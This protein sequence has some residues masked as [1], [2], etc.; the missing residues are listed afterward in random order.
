MAKGTDEN[1][2][3][4]SSGN[5]FADLG[6]LNA[7][8]EHTKV[9][10]ALAINKLIE[11]L[12]QVEAARQLRTKQPNVS[13]LRNYRLDGFSAER[14]MHF[15]NALGQDV[16]IVIRKR[17][18]W[19]AAAIVVSGAGLALKRKPRSRKHSPAAQQKSA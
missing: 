18:R 10:L 15:L 11:H 13:A 2:V 17:P 9:R 4:P 5:V 6:L 12:T 1:Q 16:E 3:Q 19:R 7:G 8:E 14:L